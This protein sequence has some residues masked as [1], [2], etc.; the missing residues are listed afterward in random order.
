MEP[1]LNKVPRDWGNLFVKSRVRYI[2]H[3]HL[4]Y[5]E[6]LVKLPKCSLYRGIVND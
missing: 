4:T 6:F 5:N 2:E 3:L 1:R